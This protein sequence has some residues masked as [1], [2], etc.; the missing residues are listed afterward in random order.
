MKRQLAWIILVVPIVAMGQGCPNLGM[1]GVPPGLRPAPTIQVNQQIDSLLLGF[2]V[3]LSN[4]SETD[5][6]NWD[7]GDSTTALNLPTSTGRSIQHTFPNSGTFRVQVYLFSGGRRL[8]TAEVTV[9]VQG[10]NIPPTASFTATQLPNAPQPRTVR[11][12]GSGSSDSDGTLTTF[13]W[14]FGDGSPAGTG[15]VIEHTYAAPGHYDVVLTVTDDRND[16]GTAQR[17]VLANVPPTAAFT[18]Q[19]TGPDEPQLLTVDFDASTSTDDDGS[20]A[21]FSWDFGDSSPAGSGAM[22]QHTYAERGLFTVVLTITDNF[23]T[24]TQVTHELNLLGNFPDVRSISPSD[25]EVDTTVSITSLSGNN[26]QVGAT[27]RLSRSGQVDISATNVVRVSDSQLTCDFDL[28][29]A[30]LGDWNVIVS[31]PGGFDDTLADGFRVVTANRVRMSTS[32]G[33]IVL[34]MDRAA[35]PGHVANFYRYIEGRLYDGIVFHRVPPNNFVIQSGAFTSNGPGSNPRLSERAGFPA[36]PSE[37][38]NGRSNVRGTIS[39]ALR[40]NDANSGTN[41]FF[42]NVGNNTNLDTGPPRFTVF[43]EVVEGL[44]VVDAI[45]AVPTTNNV[46]V[47]TLQGAS[48]FNDVPT[49]DVTIN[50][51]RRE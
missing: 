10:P 31:N 1:L 3:N 5:H 32:L 44:D 21:T 17:N 47:Q 42:I 43:G 4:H 16:T 9:A 2:T 35:A 38:P 46:P 23:G 11:F 39:L 22:P 27:V 12:D 7:F 51:V 14:N 37:A 20:I 8:A 6:I 24:T 30:A 34:Q 25:G 45:A 13:S 50:T 29:G 26:F 33:D 41:Q 49:N 48:T 15:T 28:A 40:G 18:S 19:S 36:I